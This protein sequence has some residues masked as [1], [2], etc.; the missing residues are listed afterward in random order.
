MNSVA[1]GLVENTSTSMQ[2]KLV[3]EMMVL[4]EGG[5]VPTTLVMLIKLSFKQG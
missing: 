5:L 1:D 4:M 3:A 2:N